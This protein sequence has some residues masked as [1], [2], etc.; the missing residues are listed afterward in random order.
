[1]GRPRKRQRSEQEADTNEQS[2]TS[3][4]SDCPNFY[5][6]NDT[7][8]INV[9]ASAAQNPWLSQTDIYPGMDL[10]PPY[11]VPTTNTQSCPAPA[12]D[13]SCTEGVY[14][15]PAYPISPAGIE[16]PSLISSK[17]CRCMMT[18][19][20]ILEQ[21]RTFEVFQFPVSVGLLRNALTTISGV[22]SC[23]VCADAGISA[24]QNTTMLQA[25]LFSVVDRFNVMLKSMNAEADRLQETG[26]TKP[27]KVADPTDLMIMHTGTNDCPAGLVVQV[28]GDQWRE[29]SKRALR[30]LVYGPGDCMFEL[31]DQWEARQTRWHSDLHMLLRR[32]ELFPE[33]GCEDGTQAGGC[34][35]TITRIRAVTRNLNL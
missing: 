18:L 16:S 6:P 10:F 23:Q 21:L 8:L 22:I 26:E 25:T 29:M 11:S 14:N 3:S 20:N 5:P 24:L 34:I 35:S 28:N 4:Q 12:M 13:M 33:A 9:T 17:S 32:Q 19:T 1:M 27:L 31:L 30:K 2:Q 7:L 15:Q